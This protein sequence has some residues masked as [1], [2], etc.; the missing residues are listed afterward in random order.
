MAELKKEGI[1]TIT[2]HP[3]IAEANREKLYTPIHV[4][5]HQVACLTEF[6]LISGGPL[7]GKCNFIQIHVYEP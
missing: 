6:T 2:H 3:V 7:S 5:W 1:G 4:K